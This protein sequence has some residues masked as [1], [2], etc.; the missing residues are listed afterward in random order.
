MVF[1]ITFI[2]DEQR[3]A[4]LFIMEKKYPL[5]IQTG[6]LFY[7]TEEAAEL[8]A[9]DKRT[10]ANWRARNKGPCYVRV[11]SKNSKVLYRYDDLCAWAD[12]R[13]RV[14]TDGDV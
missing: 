5:P 9:V 1:A 6:K 13:E 3:K 10:L 14:E 7:T 11:S 8:L 4:P 2:Y 12:S